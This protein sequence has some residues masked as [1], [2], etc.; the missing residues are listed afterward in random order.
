MNIQ[1]KPAAGASHVKTQSLVCGTLVTTDMKRA[2]RMYEEAMGMECVEPSQGLMYVREK[3]HKPGE[4]K[5]G[6]PYWVLEVKQVENVGVAQEMLNHWG[7]EA[8]SQ[9]AVDE[10]YEKLSANKAEYGITRVQKPFFRN[11]SYA[12]YFVDKDTNWWEV[13]YRTPELIYTALRE[14]GDQFVDP[15]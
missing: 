2:R 1:V 10:A 7:F 15:V 12:I 9:A 13:E 8:P 6:K 14:K 3:G 5:H 4:A 11:G